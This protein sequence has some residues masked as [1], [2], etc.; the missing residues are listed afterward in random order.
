MSPAVSGRI[1]FSIG[2]AMDDQGCLT[3]SPAAKLMGGALPSG[4]VVEM[5][6]GHARYIEPNFAD[7]LLPM[8][9]GPREILVSGQRGDAVAELVRQLRACA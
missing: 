3:A 1:R 7:R 9:N 2:N 8:L 4:V 6:L 5:D